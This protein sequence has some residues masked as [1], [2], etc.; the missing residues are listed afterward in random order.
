MRKHYWKDH[1]ATM[2]RRIAAGKRK[3]TKTTRKSKR[4]FEKALKDLMKEYDVL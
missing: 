3:K 2:K 1:E 4:S